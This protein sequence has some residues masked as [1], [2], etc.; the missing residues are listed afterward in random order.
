MAPVPIMPMRK[1]CIREAPQVVDVAPG[2]ARSQFGQT[3]RRMQSA[4]ELAFF[5]QKQAGQV[6]D[7]IALNQA[8]IS[9]ASTQHG[10]INAKRHLRQFAAVPIDSWHNLYS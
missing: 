9:A 5:D 6:K 3:Q 7:A 8:A 1:R 2:S 4:K 10:P